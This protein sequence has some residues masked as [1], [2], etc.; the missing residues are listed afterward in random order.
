MRPFDSIFPMQ[1]SR[2][3]LSSCKCVCLQLLSPAMHAAHN[4]HAVNRCSGWSIGSHQMR[5]P[6]QTAKQP[7]SSNASL[8][9]VC[10]CVDA[11]CLDSRSWTVQA[12]GTTSIIVVTVRCTCTKT[13]NKIVM[14]FATVFRRYDVIVVMA[15]ASCAKLHSNYLQ[16]VTALRFRYLWAPPLSL[17]RSLYT[18]PRWWICRTFTFT[19]RLLAHTHIHARAAVAR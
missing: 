8:H 9:I 13:I 18:G 19:F 10:C 12:N 11:A 6:I 15:Y 1:R 4:A 7:S 14:P 16:G 2:L 5:N 17:S 3:M